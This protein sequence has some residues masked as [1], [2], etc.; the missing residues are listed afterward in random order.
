MNMHISTMPLENAQQYE[1]CLNN[2]RKIN[3]DIEADVIRGRVLDARHNYLPDRLSLVDQLPYLSEQERRFI[4][5]IQ[6]R[7]Y[8][9]IF[10]LVERFIGAK[11]IELS[12]EH[13]LGN[14]IATEAM[15]Q[16]SAEELKHQALFRRMEVLA[17]D[18]LPPGYQMMADPN[19]VAKVVLSK[20]SWSVLGLTCH[21]E[22]F[23]QAHYL[24]SIQDNN[25]LS[26]LFK[27]VFKFHWQEESQHATLDELEWS[28]VHETLSAQEVDNS[29][30]DLIDLVVAVDGIL[31]AQSAADAAYFFSNCGRRFN[32]QQRAEIQD[33]VLRA[34]R[35]QYIVSGVQISRF[36]NALSEKLD[37]H[38][39]ERIFTAL[40]PL[41]E[42]VNSV[43]TVKF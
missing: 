11:A 14:Q 8:A 31:Q 43:A 26:P 35:W 5:Q 30:D 42:H 33:L 27:D 16:F 17:D 15:L 40:A 7:S 19:E 1:K 38:Q 4:S 13:A 12:Q 24:A 9:Y 20:S 22:I 25:N 41:L 28:R 21:I 23:T 18:T 2:S 39:L 6:G 32:A 37:E 34:Y 3:W 10:G 29:V 36:Q